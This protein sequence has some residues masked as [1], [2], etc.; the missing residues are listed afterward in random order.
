MN[1]DAWN[2]KSVWS[3]IK[4]WFYNWMFLV[5]EPWWVWRR[6]SRAEGAKEGGCYH[7]TEYNTK[8]E[9]QR[10][11]HWIILNTGEI[12]T[13]PFGILLSFLTGV[14]LFLCFAVFLGFLVCFFFLILLNSRLCAIWKQ[15]WNLSVGTY[16]FPKLTL[17]RHSSDTRIVK[18]K[19]L[20][21]KKHSFVMRKRNFP[22]FWYWSTQRT[23]FATA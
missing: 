6:W 2:M 7:P 15:T 16:S 3:K 12:L 23:I 13:L 14:A 22:G 11:F 5:L 4:R 1:F 17:L 8:W 21:S 9:F 19:V 20:V 10:R 18:L